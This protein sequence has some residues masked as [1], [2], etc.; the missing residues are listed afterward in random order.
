[1]EIRNNILSPLLGRSREIGITLPSYSERPPTKF[2]WERIKLY[3]K[4]ATLFINLPSQEADKLVFHRTIS[5][6]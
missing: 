3:F 6:E 1:M 2:R 5:I 4:K